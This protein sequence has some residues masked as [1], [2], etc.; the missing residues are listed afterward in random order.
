MGAARAGREGA[1]DS[2]GNPK[3]QE[4]ERQGTGDPFRS[5]HQ[6][7]KV[8]IEDE[9]TVAGEQASTSGQDDAFAAAVDVLLRGKFVVAF[10]GAGISVES[11]QTFDLKSVGVHTAI[12]QLVWGRCAQL[13]PKRILRMIDQ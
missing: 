9:R 8:R 5:E 7:Q 10:T 3:L 4:E 13:G 2:C 6:L 11:G 1:S 12:E